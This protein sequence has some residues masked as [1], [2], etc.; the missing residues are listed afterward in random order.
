MIHLGLVAILLVAVPLQAADLVRGVRSK[1]SAGDL[2]SGIAAIEDYKRANGTDAE[3][4]NAIGWIARGAAMLGRGDLARSYVNELRRDIPEETAE[5]IVPLGAAIEV[6]G[7]LL[8]A[9]EGRGAAIRYYESEL[10]NATAPALRSRIVKNINLLSLEGQRAPALDETLAIGSGPSSLA[11]ARGKPVLLYFWAQWCG[12]CSAQAASLSRV[13]QKY[14]PLGL[15]MI[16]ATRFYGTVEGK[17][18][19]PAEEKA[20]VEKVWNE[21]YAGLS[22][23]TSIISTET[24]ERYGASATPTFALVDRKGVVRLYTPTR[25]SEAE[26]SRQIEILLAEKE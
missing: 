10:E 1:I 9:S 25:L 23:V 24:M 13:W 20:R 16:A 5:L 22:G 3:Y 17:A 18:A 6:E 21:T 4:L 7:R 11:E 12:D 15:S 19:T 14:E 8:A 26:L 2:A